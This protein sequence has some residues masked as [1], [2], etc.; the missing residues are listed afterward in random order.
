MG[1]LDGTN[2]GADKF[3]DV[4]D[5][6]VERVVDPVDD[7]CFV[8]L[9]WDCCPPDCSVVGPTISSDFFAEAALVFACEKFGSAIAAFEYASYACVYIPRSS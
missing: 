5:E 7:C 8:W 9:S 6:E 3:N 1:L 4:L 2:V